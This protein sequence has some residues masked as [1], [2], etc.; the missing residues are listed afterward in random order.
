MCQGAR[1]RQI[2]SPQTSLFPVSFNNSTVLD[3][4]I[5]ERTKGTEKLLCVKGRG[6]GRFHCHKQT[7]FQRHLIKIPV[8]LL[9][10]GELLTWVVVLQGHPGPWGRT[11]GLPLALLY[12]DCSATGCLGKKDNGTS[13][14]YLYLIISPEVETDFT[15]SNEPGRMSSVIE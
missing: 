12:F 5:S 2:L 6:G 15:A 9:G 10:I 3:L 1:W 11:S 14:W 13:S 7:Y 4:G 8:P